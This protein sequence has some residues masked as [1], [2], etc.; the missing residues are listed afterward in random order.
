[1]RYPT[2][3]PVGSERRGLILIKREVISV[4]KSNMRH[5]KSAKDSRSWLTGVSARMQVKC[6]AT[7]LV[8]LG[9]KFLISVIT[10]GVTVN[11]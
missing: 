5:L 2:V 6:I 10:F 3:Q 8:C 9:C 1:M 4:Q 7:G 11:I